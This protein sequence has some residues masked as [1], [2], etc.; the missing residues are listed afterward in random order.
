MHG[1]LNSPREFLLGQLKIFCSF[2]SWTIIV[3]QV[4]MMFLIIPR[5]GEPN[6]INSGESIAVKHPLSLPSKTIRS[7]GLCFKQTPGWCQGCWYEHLLA[8]KMPAETQCFSLFSV[9]LHLQ[10]KV[11]VCHCGK[12][13]DEGV[14]NSLSHQIYV[15]KRATDE[16]MLAMFFS[17]LMQSRINKPREWCHPQWLGLPI[18]VDVARKTPQSHSQKSYSMAILDCARLTT[19]TS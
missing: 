9:D 11:P 15:K 1:S 18:F 14:W 10:L 6:L 3:S 5:R 17:L 12:V 8:S 13:K 7:L 2:C 4:Q 16:C 19:K